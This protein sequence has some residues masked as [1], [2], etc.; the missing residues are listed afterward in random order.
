MI[1]GAQARTA[2]GRGRLLAPTCIYYLFVLHRRVVMQ[3]AAT[4]SLMRGLEAAS[5]G[6][7][8]PAMPAHRDAVDRSR[9]YIHILKL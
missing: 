3:T 9:L 2:R 8:V 6:R 7:R 5:V 1:H 4:Y